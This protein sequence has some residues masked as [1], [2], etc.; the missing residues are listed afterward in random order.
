MNS[1]EILK[2]NKMIPRKSMIDIPLC[3]MISLQVVQPALQI[4]IDKM[5]ADFIHGYRPGAVVFYV[6]TT[7]F[8]G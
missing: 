4:D 7:N 3:K 1:V 8:V 5:K 2:K 6:L